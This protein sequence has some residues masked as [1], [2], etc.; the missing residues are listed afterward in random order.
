MALDPQFVDWMNATIVLEGATGS[1]S[2]GYGG[3]KFGTPVNVLARIEQYVVKTKTHDGNEVNT[4][5]RLYVSPVDSSS[6][7]GSITIRPPDRI[8]IP[9]G[10]IVG[11]DLQ[12]RIVNVEQHDDENSQPMYFEVLV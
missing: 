11:E 7:H 8:T 12:P 9:A 2:G 5:G 6:S 10:Y 1:S 4:R 3:R